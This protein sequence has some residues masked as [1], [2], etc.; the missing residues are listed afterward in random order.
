MG[1]R[2]PQ[3]NFI[4]IPL[5]GGVDTR[6][7]PAQL[8]PPQLITQQD[9]S[10]RATGALTP[11]YGV[12]P[13]SASLGLQ[14][15]ATIDATN[16]ELI[17][18]DSSSLYSYNFN[19]NQFIRR[20]DYTDF[21]LSVQNIVDHTVNQNYT[22][23]QTGGVRNLSTAMIGNIGIL[24][25]D[26]GSAKNNGNG[27]PIGSMVYILCYDVSTGK[28]YWST[29][30][31]G[32]SPL[33]A[34]G[35]PILVNGNQTT[36]TYTLNGIAGVMQPTV[37]AHAGKF[38]F[39]M[40]TCTTSNTSVTVGGTT[41]TGSG[42]ISNLFYL[43]P[44]ATTGIPP[45]PVIGPFGPGGSTNAVSMLDSFPLTIMSSG[46]TLNVG[47][48]S[49]LENINHYYDIVS[50][51]TDL[52]FVASYASVN[53]SNALVYGNPSTFYA[54]WSDPTAAAVTT[55]SLTPIPSQNG[56][57]GV[58]A[59]PVALVTAASI[60][61]AAIFTPYSSFTVNTYSSAS[62]GTFG[63]TRGY[64]GRQNAQVIGTNPIPTWPIACGMTGTASSFTTIMTD[65]YLVNSFTYSSGTYSTATESYLNLPMTSTRQVPMGPGAGQSTVASRMFWIP[66]VGSPAGSLVMEPAVWIYVGSPANGT[67]TA[68]YPGGSA[69]P[70]LGGGFNSFTNLILVRLNLAAFSSAKQNVNLSEV[71]ARCMYLKAL[72]FRYGTM[73]PPNVVQSNSLGYVVPAMQLVN[74]ADGLVAIKTVAVKS[75]QLRNVVALPQGALL[76]GA[77][78]RYYD[79]STTRSAGWL[80]VPELGGTFLTATTQGLA[81]LQPNF[82]YTYYF[83]YTE[84]DNYGNAIYSSPSPPYTVT[85][86]TG[87][88]NAVQIDVNEFWPAGSKNTS[89]PSGVQIFR[90]TSINPLQFYRVA[91]VASTGATL[92]YGQ[93]Y[94]IDPGPDD[95]SGNALL[96]SPPSGGEL[97]NDPPPP[98]TC[99]VAT[100]QR[101]FVASA[102]NGSY[103]FP[104]KPFYS[105]RSPVEFNAAQYVDID[106]STGP[107]NGL[108][109]LDNTVVIF[110]QRAIY[111]L[112][113][114]GPDATG[115]GGFNNPYRLSVDVGLQD[116]QSIVSTERGVF[117]RSQRGI[118]LLD[119]G[120]SS[121]TYVGAPVEA[122][123]GSN[124]V[125]DAFIVPNQAQVR[126]VFA[127]SGY[128]SQSLVYDYA[129]QIWY[130]YSL[131]ISYGSFTGV[132]GKYFNGSVYIGNNIVGSA[133][134]LQETPSV[135]DGSG[136][137]LQTPFITVGPTMHS[138][139][140]VRRINIVGNAPNQVRL[141]VRVA[142]DY[143][144]TVVKSFPTVT[145]PAGQFSVRLRPT[146]QLCQAVSI[147]LATQGTSATL[148][149]A[150]ISS[151]ALETST[152]SG[153]AHQPDTRSL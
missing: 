95:I 141:T 74:V 51:G 15:V 37:L 1:Q 63:I 118:E 89:V 108:A 116:P 3:R 2:T 21:G 124:V 139:G 34:N 153:A 127:T 115:V 103:V 148:A 96:Y 60:P 26:V 113:G 23:N 62:P 29:T 64:Y 144:T 58:A 145:L 10:A 66:A 75:G 136:S 100:K 12:S 59:N 46:T 27:N 109:N 73:R 92:Q 98:S 4:Q 50:N 33:S 18:C 24:V 138:W 133:N 22:P 94:Y 5:N 7:D 147:Y 38:I 19:V 17:G 131:P 80:R 111:L 137:N 84:Y 41:T 149:G 28:V 32:Y 104:S 123:L 45:K 52:T 30:C 72:P 25:W 20:G 126:F 82:Q 55:Y 49:L 76:T 31:G 16:D 6:T 47:A 105:G 93:Q 152:K 142:Y 71:V 61:M 90:N 101:V 106:P 53:S 140:R 114:D 146:R 69:P 35:T 121:V 77:D 107:I 128:L 78:T 86:L 150:T 79:G 54:G 132:T 110:K 68:A 125:S 129:S 130:T 91:Q 112:S 40:T 135:F 11:R 67:G 44:N 56:N 70:G 134:V 99:A 83:V 9:F 65:G 42:Y 122:A 48:A 119:R 43:T 14:D 36:T 97:P 120:G 81:T 87:A 13:M 143:D 39:G 88:N 102:E 8:Q 57:G 117:F 85:T 151:I